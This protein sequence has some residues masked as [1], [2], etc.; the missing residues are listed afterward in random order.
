M[1]VV[2]SPPAP[3]PTEASPATDFQ[4]ETKFIALPRPGGNGKPLA[5]KIRAVSI[6]DLIK[7]MDGVPELNQAPA[8]AGTTLEKAREIIVQSEG[9]NRRIAALGIVEPAFSFDQR[10]AGKA[11][12]GDVHAE[13][14]GFAIKEI[15]EFSGLAPA[16]TQAQAEA[17]TFRGVDAGEGLGAGAAGGNG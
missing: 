7:A 16:P 9:P 3:A 4:V 12:W 2:P 5:L 11:F 15:L 8:G 14:A 13:N 6:V 17:A 10:E 1:T